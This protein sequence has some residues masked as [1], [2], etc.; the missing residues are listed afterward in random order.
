MTTAITAKEPAL[1]YEHQSTQLSVVSALITIS[2]C[3]SENPASFCWQDDVVLHPEISCRRQLDFS[4]T[5]EEIWP[6]QGVSNH[7]RASGWL[8]PGFE[9]PALGSALLRAL[10]PVGL[11]ASRPPL[12]PLSSLYH[13]L[14]EIPGGLRRAGG[15]L[16]AGSATATGW[17]R[18][19]P[20]AVV[21]KLL[22]LHRLSAREALFSQ[23]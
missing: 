3:R 14:A 8:F 2:I 20:S 10:F 11:D 23:L 12:L 4:L 17:A 6:H 16:R 9:S 19:S 1:T 18:A 13:P 22:H 21:S 15:T 5:P 7:L